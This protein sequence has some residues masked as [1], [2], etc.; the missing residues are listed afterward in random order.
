VFHGI[1]VQRETFRPSPTHARMPM[2]VS[3]RWVRSLE[4]TT[5]FDTVELFMTLDK[6][7]DMAFGAARVIVDSRSDAGAQGPCCLC[8]N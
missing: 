4:F 1:A 3:N 6:F 5:A 7:Q 8:L 2:M